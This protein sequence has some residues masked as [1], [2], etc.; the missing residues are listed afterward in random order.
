M[1]HCSMRCA[2][3]AVPMRYC[4]VL[5]RCNAPPYPRAALAR[6]Q[7]GH[8]VH[9]CSGTRTPT[10]ALGSGLRGV[11]C[12]V[13]CAVLDGD[14]GRCLGA[15]GHS[16]VFHGAGGRWEGT[17]GYSRGTALVLARAAAAARADGPRVRCCRA[18]ARTCPVP[19]AATSARRAPCGSRRRPRAAPPPPPRARPRGLRCP[20]SWTPTLTP[21][22]AAT[23]GPA[24]TGRGTTPTRSAPATLAHSCCAPHSRPVRRQRAAAA[25]RAQRVHR[26]HRPRVPTPRA[27][28]IHGRHID[29]H[30]YIIGIYTHI[31]TR[32]MPTALVGGAARQRRRTADGR[33]RA[34]KG[35]RTRVLEHGY[36]KGIQKGY[37]N[38]G[39]QKKELKKGG[40]R[41][42]RYNSTKTGVLKKGYS[43]GY[44]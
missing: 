3:T 34:R 5:V 38:T 25:P 41:L 30:T 18:Q 31:Y 8:A 42:I 37:S 24:T 2:P 12:G 21:R 40:T 28:V 23:T 15:R 27:C 10:A 14:F 35:T 33:A 39:T 44:S 26:R 20:L 4:K 32:M 29:A 17:P 22:G 36:S 7:V 11:G 16:W 43:T 13:G 19:R 1:R 9:G 6:V